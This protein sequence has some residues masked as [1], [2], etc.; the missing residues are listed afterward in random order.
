M[1]QGRNVIPNAIPNTSAVLVAIKIP[2]L[3]FRIAKKRAI[4]PKD[5]GTRNRIETTL[6]Q[7]QQIW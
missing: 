4:N 6:F 2:F 1:A 5:K 3:F 7:M